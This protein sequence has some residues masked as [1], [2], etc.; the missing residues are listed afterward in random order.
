MI[1]QGEKKPLKE[2]FATPRVA[3][4][5]WASSWE[6]NSMSFEIETCRVAVYLSGEHDDLE[7]ASNVWFKSVGRHQVAHSGDEPTRF[8]KNVGEV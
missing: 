5:V 1:V 4:C 8:V 3:E 6:C 7:D 2:K